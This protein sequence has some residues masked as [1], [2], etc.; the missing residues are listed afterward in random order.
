MEEPS[1]LLANPRG[2]SDAL[3]CCFKI[4]FKAPN[5]ALPGYLWARRGDKIELLT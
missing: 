3:M 4:A 5:S 1:G 2:G